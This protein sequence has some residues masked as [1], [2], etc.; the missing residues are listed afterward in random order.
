MD[1]MSS[2]FIEAS[3]ALGAGNFKIIFRHVLPN[4]TAPVL[5]H[6]SSAAAEALLMCTIIGYI[7]IGINPPYP[8]WG[9]LVAGGYGY[10]RSRPHIALFPCFAV[11]LCALSLNLLGNGLRDA[12]D[13]GLS[14]R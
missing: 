11:T 12:L 1:V 4:V 13:P 7:G 3:R 6:I 2:E 9:A 5:I 10:L 8:E 14:E